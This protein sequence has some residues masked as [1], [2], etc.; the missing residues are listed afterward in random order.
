MTR[1]DIID[2]LK[3]LPFKRDRCVVQIDQGVRDF[4]VRAFYRAADSVTLD[5]SPPGA[6][7][8]AWFE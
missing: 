1:A 6:A 5:L 3:R 2:I 7:F 8:E 4:L